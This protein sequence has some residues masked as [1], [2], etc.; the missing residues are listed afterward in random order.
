MRREEEEVEEEEEEEVEEFLCSMSIHSLTF[1][2]YLQ[3]NT[4]DTTPF[5]TQKYKIW[6]HLTRVI[7]FHIII[8]HILQTSQA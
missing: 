3:R 4:P 5:P 7:F 1:I 2:I 8:L 6:Y